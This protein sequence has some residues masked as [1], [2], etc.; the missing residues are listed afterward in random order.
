MVRRNVAGS[1][2][3]RG[4]KTTD[5]RQLSVT[6]KRRSIAEPWVAAHTEWRQAY[7]LLVWLVVEHCQVKFSFLSFSFF[8]SLF[9]ACCIDRPRVEVVE[10]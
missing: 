6:T 10:R 7:P 4:P 3:T 8:F 5:F 1:R 9:K 2:S